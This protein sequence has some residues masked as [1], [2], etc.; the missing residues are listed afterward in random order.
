MKAE[1]QTLSGRLR[2]S[3]ENVMKYFIARDGSLDGLRH[4]IFE[5]KVLNL[6]LEKAIIEKAGVTDPLETKK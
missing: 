6:L 1:L 4:S 3:P 5:E 2:L